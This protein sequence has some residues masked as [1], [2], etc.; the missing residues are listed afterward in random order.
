[1]IYAVVILV[2][3]LLL[4]FVYEQ[5]SRR[6]DRRFRV[7]GRLVEVDGYRLHV[8]DEGQGGP[9]VV[10]LSGAGDSSASWL[11]VRKAV[12]RFTRVLAYDRPGLGNSDPGPAPDPVGTVEE[13]HTLLA[14]SGAP[15]PYVLA[16]HSLGGLIARLYA[17]R[18]PEQVAG[19]V[20]VDSTHEFLKT[21]KKFLQ[22]MAGIG[23]MIRFFRALSP[24]GLHRFLGN[25]LHIMPMYASERRYYQEQLTPDEYEQWASVANH[26]CTSSAG[27]AEVQSI[28]TMLEA[29][30]QQ[31]KTSEAAPQFGDLPLAVLTNPSFGE[32][33]AEMHR[34]LA[35]RSTNSIHRISDRNGHSLQMPRPELVIDAIR[36][37]V[38]QVKE[39]SARVS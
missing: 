4:G 38:D 2:G 11:T 13:L 1:M 3:L 31:L 18:Y 8:T 14:R 5:V 29:A 39:R 33:W 6:R 20:M 15:G 23:M 21:D 7:P 35:R 27:V 16:G 19:L 24:F 9:T 17:Y 36:H 34:E 30:N 26:N 25:V 37:V 12:A 28:P 32:G 22:G 10:V